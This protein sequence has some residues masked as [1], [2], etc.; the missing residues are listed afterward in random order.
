ML[1]QSNSP[2]TPLAF[3]GYIRKRLP[4]VLDRIVGINVIKISSG[5]LVLSPHPYLYTEH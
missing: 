2:H 4:R 1:C 5:T 3:V